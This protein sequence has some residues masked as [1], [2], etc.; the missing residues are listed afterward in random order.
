MRINRREI[1]LILGGGLLLILLFYGLFVV[2]PALSKQESLEK[3]IASKERDLDEMMTLK[4]RWEAFKRM[5]GEAREALARRG[6]GFTLLSFLEGVS[7][8]VGIQDKIQYMKPLDSLEES[9]G[10]KVVGM[11]IKLEGIGVDQVVKFLYEIEFSSRLLGIKKIKVQTLD[12]G[13]V[14]SLRVT[15]QV[16][17]VTTA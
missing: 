4:A 6:G 5:Q 2:S 3:A 9:E 13:E 11:E 7:R 14:H 8:K 10:M 15:L 17:T 1:G 12:R 16:D